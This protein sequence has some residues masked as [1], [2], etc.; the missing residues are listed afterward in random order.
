MTKMQ[1]MSPMRNV[2]FFLA[3]PCIAVLLSACDVDAITNK[4]TTRHT[5]VNIEF[6][7]DSLTPEEAQ[8]R[9]RSRCGESEI[10]SVSQPIP[11]AKEGWFKVS[12]ECLATYDHDG[13]LI[14]NET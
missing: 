9:A 7:Q 10:L 13:H 5:T 1:M 4:T 6:Q 12:A 14:A 11:M 3:L 2:R 8:D